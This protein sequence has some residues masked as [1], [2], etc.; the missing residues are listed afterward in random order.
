VARTILVN[1][2]R[3]HSGSGIIGD[4]AAKSKKSWLDSGGSFLY[5]A[6]KISRGIL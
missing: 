1:D 5:T 6:G 4:I 2:N 3:T